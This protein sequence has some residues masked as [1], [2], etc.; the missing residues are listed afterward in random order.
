MVIK[1]RRL[2]HAGR[3][4]YFD[5]SLPDLDDRRMGRPFPHRRPDAIELPGPPAGPP[6]RPHVQGPLCDPRRV[7]YPGEGRSAHRL[8]AHLAR[9]PAR[10]GA[11]R[12][13]GLHA[14]RL[15]VRLGG[16]R[17]PGERPGP[18]RLRHP[19]CGAGPEPGGLHR[20][21]RGHPVGDLD[22]GT[23]WTTRPTRT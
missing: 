4:N 16:R 2:G 20:R 3:E 17:R 18:G 11:E 22:E 8:P 12:P 13:G 19:G 1:I 7:D 15:E 9:Q 10:D 5:N 23:F 21:E 6:H 14:F